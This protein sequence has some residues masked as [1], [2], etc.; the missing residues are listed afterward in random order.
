MMDFLN[1]VAEH[2]PDKFK[3]R[4]FVDSL[5]GQPESKLLGNLTC[6]RI[7]K[8]ALQSALG[9]E[10]NTPWWKGLSRLQ[11]APTVNRDRKVLVLVCGPEQLV[12]PLFEIAYSLI[13]F[14]SGW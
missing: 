14:R 13:D 12:L 2:H 6:E 11:A 10:C 1:N 8:S 9:T 5:G 4:V 7:G 3:F